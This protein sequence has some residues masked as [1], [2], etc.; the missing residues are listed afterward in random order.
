MSAVIEQVE[1]LTDEWIGC[2]SG[3]WKGVIVDG[4]FAHPAKVAFNLAR[5][6]YEHAIDEN[7]IV[8]GDT[9]VDPFGGIGGC[10][11]HGLVN[12]MRVVTCELEQKFVDL[13]KENR[14]LW[15]AKFTGLPGFDA[16]NWTILQ[17][18]SRK[19]ASVIREAGIAVSSP[20]YAA[21]E[22]SDYLMT[23]DG[24]TR[25]RD[26]KRGFKQ[27]HGSFRGSES[28][29]DTEG[30]LGRMRDKEGSFDLAVSSPPYAAVSPEKSSRSVDYA[31]QYET[32]RSQ[33][34]GASFEKFV[35]TQ[36]LHSQGYGS[37]DGQLARMSEGSLCVSSPP[38][39]QPYSSGGGINV[40][41]Y[42]PDG[43]DKVGSRTYQS[44]GGDRAEG[45]LETLETGSVELAITS[46]PYNPPMSQDHNG[47]RGGKRGTEPSETGAFVKYGNSEGQ[48]EGL[49]MEGFD[50]AITS[51]P[52]EGLRMDG[53]KI[54]KEEQ[55]GM[56]P[57]TDEPVDAWFTTRDQTNIAN[58]HPDTFW[59]ASR[60]ILE[61]LYSVLTP[62]AHAIFIVKA[63]VRN[64]QIVDFPCQWA[65][66]CEAVG[67][68]LIQRSPRNV[69]R[70]LRNSRRNVW[71]GQRDQS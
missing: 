26:V 50:A 31:K 23:D 44:Q 42:G 8:S 35:A 47:S 56:R 20:P 57:Y 18:D 53:G 32:Y 34:G 19:L 61:Q 21:N 28:Y 10:A 4:A 12:G 45:N 66:L 43:K 70:A 33:G 29:G 25:R 46:P 69:D 60:T 62:G 41:G 64:K 55:G 65:R 17:G 16:D 3:G 63:F 51:P 2:Y 38:F 13:A 71:R 54:A 11:F 39:P 9:V 52:Y 24:K 6:I 48:I 37:S 27:G 22:K 67:F 59:S 58:N 36:E 5:R 40:K 30:Q 15:R 1:I 7:W 68:K 49:S 14:E